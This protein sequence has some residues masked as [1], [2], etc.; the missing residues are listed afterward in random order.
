MCTAC[1]GRIWRKSKQSEKKNTFL[2][3][4]KMIFF[5]FLKVCF[6]FYWLLDT[7]IRRPLPNFPF[8]T[9]FWTIFLFFFSQKWSYMR[10]TLSRLILW[11]LKIAIFWKCIEFH[12]AKVWVL[13][14]SK[15]NL[16]L[17]FYYNMAFCVPQLIG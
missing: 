2:R 3:I 8:R 9:L 6:F 14:A 5:E 12:M 17:W 15:T 4:L 1:W 16:D 13:F 11:P 7:M 10:D